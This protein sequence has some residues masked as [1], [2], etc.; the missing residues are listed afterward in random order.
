MGVSEIHGVVLKMESKLISFE[1][2]RN[3]EIFLIKK[4]R[5]FIS[6]TKLETQKSINIKMDE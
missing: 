2:S 5:K 4:K 3:K 6:E 1:G